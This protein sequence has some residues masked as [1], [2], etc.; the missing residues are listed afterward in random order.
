MASSVRVGRNALLPG[1]GGVIIAL[2]D[3]PLVLPSTVALLTEK[4]EISP[5]SIII[6]CH[7]GRR[8]HPLLFPRQILD[9]L[10]EDRILRDLV[11]RKQELLVHIDVEDP[12]VLLDMDTPDEY[13]RIRE[14]SDD[15]LCFG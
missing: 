15:S 14:L 11:C 3:Y 5:D 6:P 10:T 7:A 4:N 12:G 9:E 13:R 1:F 2:C 8:G